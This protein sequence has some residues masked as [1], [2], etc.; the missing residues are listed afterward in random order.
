VHLLIEADDKA[1]LS[2]GA[3]GACIRWARAV[4]R[5]LG[6]RG[7]VWADRYHARALRTPRE[8]R[9]GIV[10]VLMNWRKHMVG[11]RGWDFRSSAQWFDGW[12]L[13]PT[14]G[15]P[16]LASAPAAVERPQTWLLGTGWKREGRI[17]LGERPKRVLG[18]ANELGFE[19]DQTP[20]KRR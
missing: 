13:P 4:N 9:L 15:P 18:G 6:R 12:L 3:A 14:S 20:T 7:R 1:S 2:R 16:E 11:A 8:V 19:P 17:R 10:Y 5:A